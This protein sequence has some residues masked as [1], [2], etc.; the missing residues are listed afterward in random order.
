MRAK[1]SVNLLLRANFSRLWRS[2]SFWVSVAVMSAISVFELAVGYQPR[3]QGG[4][5]ILDNRYMI[6]ALLSGVVL[7]AFCSLFT[8]SEYSDGTM[9]NKV[10]VGH[11]RTAVYLS[12]LA[13]CAAAGVLA[14]CGYILPM[15]IVGVPLLGPFTMSVSSLL[16]FTLCAFIMT[17]AMCAIF[18]M[19]AMLNQNKAVVAVICIFLAYFL[20]FL[21][22]YLNTRLTE[23]AVIPAREYIENGQILVRE[24]MPNPSYVQGVKRTVFEILYGLPG[25]QA[26]QLLATAEACPVRLPLASLGAIAVSTTAGAA[27]FRRKDLK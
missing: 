27:L 8:G 17:A 6:F 5:G 19:I 13:V 3:L 20:L 12:N 25:C 1:L 18:T 4:A 11:S 23:Q 16:W 21:G 10:A 22:I 14:C 7:S 26:V 2:A 24:A 9:R 15:V